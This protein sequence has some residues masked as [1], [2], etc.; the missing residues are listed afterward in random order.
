MKF[1]FGQFQRQIHCKDRWNFKQKLSQHGSI[2]HQVKHLVEC[3]D[4]ENIEH[5]EDLKYTE[6]HL[7]KQDIL[8][9]QTRWVLI[10]KLL[11]N[12]NKMAVFILCTLHLYNLSLDWLLGT[13]VQ[14]SNCLSWHV[15]ICFGILRL[16]STRYP[17][18]SFPKYNCPKSSPSKTC[19]P[20]S[21]AESAASSTLPSTSCNRGGIQFA[22]MSKLPKI[23]KTVVDYYWFYAAITCARVNQLR[24]RWI[25]LQD[26]QY[27]SSIPGFLRGTVDSILSSVQQGLNQATTGGSATPSSPYGYSY[28]G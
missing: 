15:C 16:L 22:Q 8:L 26:P 9:P 18:P 10:R 27:R 1:K 19:H 24:R 17:R 13:F 14:P 23:P 6:N 7:K 4:K 21:P 12:W 20:K 11:L 5:V 2:R 28:Q 25:P 3:V